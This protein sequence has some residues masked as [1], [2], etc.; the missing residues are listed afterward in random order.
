MKTA[1]KVLLLGSVVILTAASLV[2]F[3]RSAKVP[4]H[5]ASGTS[6]DFATAE[7][8]IHSDHKRC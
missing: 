1:N 6:T 7:Q 4:E 5:K 3:G 2:V 8:T